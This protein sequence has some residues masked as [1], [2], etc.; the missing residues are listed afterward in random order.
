MYRSVLVIDDERDLCEMISRILKK[1]GF[2]VDCAYNLAEGK[3]KLITRYD[4]VMLDNN[5]PDG[6]G[7]EFLQ[8]HPVEF[9]RSFVIM[10]SADPVNKLQKDAAHDKIGGFLRKPFSN[11][12][13]R[14]MVNSVTLYE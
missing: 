9:M 6:K 2:K 1:D 4:I 3:Q 5:L 8:M 14:E 13:M 10:I 11:E 12:R 7:L